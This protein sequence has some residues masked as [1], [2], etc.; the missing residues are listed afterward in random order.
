MYGRGS[1]RDH[2]SGGRGQWD[3]ER[4]SRGGRG[5]DRDQYSSRGR[6]SREGRDYR[7]GRDGRDYDRQQ[8]P[9]RDRSRSRERERDMRQEHDDRGRRGG[10]RGFGHRDYNDYH[11]GIPLQ[12]FDLI[13]LD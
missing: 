12:Y 8:A 7:E 10:D 2:P 13:F 3:G 5:D 6:D 11:Q 1:H 9:R 4:E